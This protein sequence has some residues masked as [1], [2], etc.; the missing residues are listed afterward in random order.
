MKQIVWRWLDSWSVAASSTHADQSHIQDRKIHWLRI[1]P[2]IG[3]HLACLSVL[4]V[5]VSGFALWFMLGFYVLRMFAITGFY[6]RYFSHKT[7]QTS[8]LVQF[9]FGLIGTMSSQRGPLWWAAHHRH[10]HRHTDQPEDRHSPRDGFWYSHMGWFLNQQNFATDQKLIR[11][12]LKYPELVWL[13][14]FS[15]PITVLTGASIWALGSWL[16]VSYPQLGTSG[17]QLFVWGFLVSTVL[18]T[19]A[20]LLINSLAHHLGSR[21]FHTPDDSR[22]NW[23]LALI[24]L[25]EGWH[26]NHHFYAGSVRQGFYWWQID[27]TFYLL[28]VMSWLGLVW[29]L[30][31]V[32][33]RVYLARHNPTPMPSHT[34]TPLVSGAVQAQ[35]AKSSK[36]TMSSKTTTPSTNASSSNIISAGFIERLTEKK[37]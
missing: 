17:A 33:K 28:K 35:D 16:A 19:H 11:D 31:P 34:S 25:G 14:R 4:W 18:L 37:S 21:S 1:L 12:W 30:K 6:H 26:N 29:Q 7:F 27:V 13:D 9:I 5:G 23:F 2:F 24:T 32:P 8:R 20:T 3:L 36:T 22:N 10:H 15:L